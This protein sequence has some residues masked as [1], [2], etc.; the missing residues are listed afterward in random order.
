VQWRARKSD[1]ETKGEQRRG[2]S[3][4]ASARKCARQ[5]T[6]EGPAERSGEGGDEIGRYRNFNSALANDRWTSDFITIF[7]AY[8]AADTIRE[9]YAVAKQG[10]V[11]LEIHQRAEE[12]S[13]VR[14]IPK[15]I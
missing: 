9:L 15:F 14:S 13:Q 6:D 5:A 11:Y 4:L 12:T 3:P 2:N 8:R 1:T 10:M 7:S